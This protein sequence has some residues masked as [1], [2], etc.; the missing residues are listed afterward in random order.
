MY[1][2]SVCA[3]SEWSFSPSSVEFLQSGL[4]GFQIHILWELL[5]P[6][7]DPQA[8]KPD[9]ELRTFTPVENFCDI[10]NFQF[11]GI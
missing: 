2:R 8:G 5:L 7:L 3:L 9:L 4:A 11:V 10:R 6:M 1:T